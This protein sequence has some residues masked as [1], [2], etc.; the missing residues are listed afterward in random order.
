[1]I[2]TATE[3]LPAA[4]ASALVNGDLSNVDED[5][6]LWAESN[7]Q[8]TSCLSCS[9]EPSPV[10]FNGLL[11]ECLE[12]SFVTETPKTEDENVISNNAT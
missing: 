9:E 2:A 10:R 7:P 4:W 8:Y 5:Y 12:Y 6:T 1:M 3:W 11:T